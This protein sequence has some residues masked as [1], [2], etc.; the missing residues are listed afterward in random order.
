MKEPRESVL[1][2]QRRRRAWIEAQ[3]CT[4][5]FG[6]EASPNGFEPVEARI[7]SEPQPYAADPN[8]PRRPF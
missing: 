8:R 5:A 2:E 6:T 4:A 7:V 3:P 1:D